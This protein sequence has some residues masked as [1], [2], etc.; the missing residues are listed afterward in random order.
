MNYMLNMGG[1]LQQDLWFYSSPG[2]ANDFLGNIVPSAR[3]Y[4][5]ITGWM[6][7]SF[8]QIFP[9]YDQDWSTEYEKE[10]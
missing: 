4:E 2:T 7:A 10:N 3:L 1:R 8:K 6:E 9:D 5:K